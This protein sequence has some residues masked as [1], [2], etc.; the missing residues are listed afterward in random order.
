MRRWRN[1]N[2]RGISE[3]IS[4]GI[5]YVLFGVT[6][7]LGYAINKIVRGNRN[8]DDVY[9]VNYVDG[10]FGY[11]NVAES[12]FDVSYTVLEFVFRCVLWFVVNVIGAMIVGVVLYIVGF[13]VII[14]AALFAGSNTNTVVEEY[15]YYH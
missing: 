14:F 15:Y 5:A 9:E 3:V 12:V 13:I 10:R 11:K 8:R 1:V 4:K 6:W 7:V 2:V